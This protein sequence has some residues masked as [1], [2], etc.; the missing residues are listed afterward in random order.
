MIAGGT[1]LC[2][3][4]T[5]FLR[6]FD[7]LIHTGRVP[8]LLQVNETE[9]T[10]EIGAAVTYSRC[11]GV[12]AAHYADIREL[13]ERLGSLQIRNQGTIG[14]NVGNASPIGDMPPI[15][16]ALDARLVLRCGDSTR[17]LSVQDYFIGYKVTAQQPSE[18]IERIIVPRPAAGY[19][20]RVYKISKRLEDDISASC[21]AFYLKVE[22]GHVLDARIAFGGMAEIP[23]RAAHCEQALIGQPWQPQTIT[24]AMQALSSDFQ[25][26]S[27]FRASADYRL[28]VSQNLLKRLY[29]ELESAADPLR[30]THYA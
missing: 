25:P 20:F 27:D 13:L 10:I 15:L 28:A 9:A 23:R 2:L 30:V 26:I 19:A 22:A 7:V 21:G 17:E 16:I 18:F 24:A 1:D 3:E 11:A 14:G 4:F 5:Q 29:L 12:L 8:E 6:E